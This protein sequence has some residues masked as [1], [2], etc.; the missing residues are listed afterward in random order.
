MG[1]AFIEKKTRPSDLPDKWHTNNY[2]S[3][4]KPEQSTF[5]G[6]DTGDGDNGMGNVQHPHVIL[7]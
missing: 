7:P 5:S 4:E 3:Y 1:K 2:R 6:S